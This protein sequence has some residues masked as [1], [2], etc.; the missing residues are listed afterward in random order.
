M[1]MITELVVRVRG[2]LLHI[3]MC[4]R[5][6]GRYSTKAANN[7]YV[8]ELESERGLCANP[9]LLIRRHG[10]LVCALIKWSTNVC[11][12]HQK[13]RNQTIRGLQRQSSSGE[14]IGGG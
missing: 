9:S 13:E 2:Q 14:R 10:R 11:V 3:M 6:K 12:L 8:A 1:Y 5:T 7:R 4:D